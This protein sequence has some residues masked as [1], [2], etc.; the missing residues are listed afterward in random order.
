MDCKMAWENLEEAI[1]RVEQAG[2]MVDEL[3]SATLQAGMAILFEYP[4]HEIIKQVSSSRLPTR[5]TV[6]WLVYEARRSPGIGQQAIDDL[7]CCWQEQCGSDGDL[8]PP[9]TPPK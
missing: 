3:L 7:T 2:M 5:P 8:I 1:G 6:S 9:P 4:A